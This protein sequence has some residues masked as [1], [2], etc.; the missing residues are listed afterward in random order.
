[1][2]CIDWFVI[3]VAKEK[4][5]EALNG[6][7]TAIQVMHLLDCVLYWLIDHQGS[8]EKGGRS[9]NESAVEIKVKLLFDYRY[10]MIWLYGN[11]GSQGKEYSS[12]QREIGID[13]VEGRLWYFDVVI[14]TQV[15]KEN[16]SYQYGA[17]AWL[18]KWLKNLCLYCSVLFFL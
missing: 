12:T 15:V 6:S 16:E 9:N 4:K 11:R 14:F 5:T 17:D 1:M 18:I 2:W 8:Q 3:V 10:V 13:K 7:A